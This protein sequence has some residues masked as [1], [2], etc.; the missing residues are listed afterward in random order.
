MAAFVLANAQTQVFAVVTS[1]STSFR[2]TS[3]LAQTKSKY[4]IPWTMSTTI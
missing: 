4:Q 2:H 3:Q 1:T